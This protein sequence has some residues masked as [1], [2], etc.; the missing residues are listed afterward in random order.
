MGYHLRPAD[1]DQ[2]LLLPP[3]LDEW[4]PEDHLA[5]FVHD[6]VGELDLEP[7]YTEL[8]P[9]GR[10][11]ASFDPE[12]MVALL[13][14]AYCVGVRSSRQIERAC[15]VDV[16][17]RVLACNQAPD[18]STIARFRARHEA[19]L[20]SLFTS[21]L[22]LCS[23]AGMASVGLVALDSTKILAS[24]SM[25]AN[26]T[27][28][29]IQA[30]VDKMFAEAEAIDAAEDAA[31]GEARGDEAPAALRGRTDRRR[32][33]A[34]ARK[35]LEA[36]AAAEQ[37]AHE[38]HLLERA[39]A[40]LESGRKLRGR[41]PVAPG[42]SG[43]RKQPRVNLT[44]PNSK[45]LSGSNG[46]LQGYTAQAVANQQQVIIAV[47]V[48]AEQNDQA[49]F[50][51]MIEAVVRELTAAG[52]LERPGTLVA[53]AGYVSEDNLKDLRDGDPDCYVATRNLKRNPT[54][55]N[56]MHGPLRAGSTSIDKMDRKVSTKK[57]RAIYRKRQQLIEPVFGQIK[58]ARGIR[59]FM[60]RGLA[61][62]DAEWHLIA[63]THNLLKLYRRTLVDPA[64]APY[65][66]MA[67]S[68]A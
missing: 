42:Q 19:A 62:A 67:V 34:E 68:L 66:R 5:F 17:F 31:F 33:F 14:Y 12:M 36:E 4:L 59:R 3:S 57:G 13:L 11:G 43:R 30:E 28:A 60:R 56:A 9:D 48:R 8:R 21:S 15:L 2:L 58:E 26:R 55:R 27:A 6:L 51:P 20:R 44:D 35:A 25:A 23:K 24:A 47:G 10:G 1:R 18:H 64:A 38:A 50:H 40:E 53:D 45:L 7:F 61:A 39:S 32:R 65:S 54:P 46:Y 37:A 41:K 16:A 22:A 49:Q 52:I 29:Q 63:A